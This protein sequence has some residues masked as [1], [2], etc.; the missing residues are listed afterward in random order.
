[1]TVKIK[2]HNIRIKNKSR[3]NQTLKTFL[4][5]KNL[6]KIIYQLKKKLKVYYSRNNKQFLN[7]KIKNNM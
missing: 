5:S 4:D 3:K 7:R 6:S 1:M 2:G